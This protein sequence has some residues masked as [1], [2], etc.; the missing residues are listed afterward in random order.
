MIRNKW[1]D[2]SI[3]AQVQRL[4][5]SGPWLVRPVWKNGKWI[6]SGIRMGD[7]KDTDLQSKILGNQ[8]LKSQASAGAV[9]TARQRIKPVPSLFI[10]EELHRALKELKRLGHV[11]T[12]GV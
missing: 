9:K 11:T 2:K 5:T 6:E 4:C 8:K 12:M 1:N 7:A 3:T 10:Q